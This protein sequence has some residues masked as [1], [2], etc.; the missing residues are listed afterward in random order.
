MKKSDLDLLARACVEI[1]NQIRDILKSIDDKDIAKS[2][3]EEK[4]KEE[5]IEF[6]T[7][8]DIPNDITIMFPHKSISVSI[9]A[10]DNNWSDYHYS[11]LGHGEDLGGVDINF[12]RKVKALKS[13]YKTE[14][15]I[16]K[17]GESEFSKNGK[18]VKE[19][20]EIFLREG[21]LRDRMLDSIGNK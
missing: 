14:K 20:H 4:L 15:F 11:L 10:E 12:S 9:Y 8:I 13:L 19:V 17:H 18:Y 7:D 21:I 5:E 3:I 1:S 16:K 6:Y 2:D